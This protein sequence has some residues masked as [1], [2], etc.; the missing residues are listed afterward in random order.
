MRL[1]QAPQKSNVTSPGYRFP[2]TPAGGVPRYCPEAVGARQWLFANS[3]SFLRKFLHF[4]ATVLLFE[5]EYLGQPLP[6]Y[7]YT[8]PANFPF[9]YRSKTFRAILSV[10]C[11]MSRS[12][13]N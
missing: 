1:P 6:Q 11:S 12:L 2:A 13:I 10:S 8:V 4:A 3:C 7:R 5:F 9:V